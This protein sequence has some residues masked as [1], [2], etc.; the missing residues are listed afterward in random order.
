MPIVCFPC[1]GRRNARSDP[2]PLRYGKSWHA[3]STPRV[4]NLRFTSA[5][6]K[7]PSNLPPAPPRI[8]P[9]RPI[10]HIMLIFVIFISLGTRRARC[11]KLMSH[12]PCCEFASKMQASRCLFYAFHA[13]THFLHHIFSKMLFLPR[14]GAQFC[15]TISCT[16]D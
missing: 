3:E 6:L 10:R 13:S 2:P 11:K 1:R 9:G 5:D 12:G 8:P 7:P 15:K 4:H 16:F 14:R